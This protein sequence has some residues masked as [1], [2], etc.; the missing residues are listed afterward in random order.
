MNL[1]TVKQVASLTGVTVRTLQFYDAIGL[2]KPTQVTDAG[3]RLYDDGALEALQQILFFK[4]LDFTLK[5][6][7]AVMATPQYDR[8]EAFQ[9]QRALLQMKRDRLDN[10]LRLLDRLIKGEK[11]MNFDEFDQNTYLNLL[12]DFKKTHADEIVQRLGSL[13]NF[14]TLLAELESRGQ[15]ITE[16]AVRH[17]GSLEGYASAMKKSFADF[18][19]HGPAVDPDRVNG[20][21]AQTD[22][23]TRRLMSI[24]SCG[25][26]SPEVQQ[27][28]GELVAAC[29]NGLNLDQGYWRTMAESYA[30]NSAFIQATDGKYGAGASKFISE[31]LFSYL[32]RP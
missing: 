18:L 19:S 7:K 23:I 1:M 10:L 15:D 9:K 11:C 26:A 3:Y 14:D 6:I 2:L 4:E 13:E 21:V 25:A 22:E 8:K 31:A 5:E 30:S 17:Y 16:L 12:A 24:R 20:L 29:D 28:V 32:N 27:I